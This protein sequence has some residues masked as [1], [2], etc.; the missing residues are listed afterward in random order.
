M[1]PEEI[2]Q[3]RAAL[4]AAHATLV[5]EGAVQVKVEDA[6]PV[7]SAADEDEAPHREMDQAIASQRNRERTQRL[8]AL[9]G[10]LSRLAN[11]PDSFGICDGCSEPIPM[12]RLVLLPHVRRCVSCQSNAETRSRGRRHVTDY[13]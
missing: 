4:L 2:P 3:V 9:E 6:E 10:A 11:D 12:A 13:R 5:A 1:E 8:H 7:A